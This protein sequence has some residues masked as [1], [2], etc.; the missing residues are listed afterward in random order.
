MDARPVGFGLPPAALP[1]PGLGKQTRLERGLGHVLGQRP[2]QPGDLETSDCRADRRRSHFDPTG[3]LTARYDAN[4][5]QP[6]HFAH[7]AHGRSLCWHQAPPS[8]S[9]RSGPD[10]HQQRHP[11]PGDM[12]E[13]ISE[14]WA[15]SSW[16]H[17]RP[18]LVSEGDPSSLSS[19][20]RRA[21]R[22]QCSR[23]IAFRRAFRGVDMRRISLAQKNVLHDSERTMRH[24]R[25]VAQW[26]RDVHFT[27]MVIFFDIRGG[28]NR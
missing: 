20:A 4:E 19:S 15:T 23:R 5:L 13:I 22:R 6:Q 10:S 26:R 27:V 11:T 12:G 7:V 25:K 28:L 2:A 1:R 24:G 14:W 9:R 21:S 18:F 3:D 16:N 17:E 8:K